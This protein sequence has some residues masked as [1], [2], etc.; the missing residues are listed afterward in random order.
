MNMSLSR[1]ERRR[2]GQSSEFYQ[3]MRKSAA[4]VGTTI[5]ACSVVAPFLTPVQADAV[6]N[7]VVRSNFAAPNT[8][9][10][11]TEI[12]TYAQPVAQAND[13]YA[14]VMIAQAI[15]ESGWGRSALSQSPNHNLFGIKGSHNGQTVY[16]NTA[17]YLNNQWLTMKEPFKKY[18]SYKESFE[19]NAR[20]LRNVSLGNGNYYYAGAWKSNT[21]SYRDA[22]QWLTGRYATAPNY[23]SSLNTVIQQYGLTKYDTPASGNAGG[24][25]TVSTPNTATNPVSKP[26]ATSSVS[27]GSQ[28]YTVASGDSVWGIANKFG[29]TMDQLCSWNNIRNN[30][31]YPG[32]K[33]TINGGTAKQTTNTGT[34]ST[35]TAS[36]GSYTVAS[37][38]SVWSVANKHGITMDQLRNWNN[39][40]NDFI[41]PG[42]RLVVKNGT[43]S[44]SQ[45]NTTTATSS[46]N[47]GRYTVASGDSVW[48]VANKHGIT[49]DQLRSWNNIKND[50]IYPGQALI[51]KNSGNKQTSSPT[52]ASTS[53]SSSAGSQKYTV[54]SGDSVWSIA[55][56]FG[57]TM[58]QFRSWNNIKNDY[59]YPGQSVRVSG[60]ATAANQTA[61]TS[62]Y[63][64]VS[65][66]SVWGIA[67]KFGISR[68]QFIQWN[69]IKDNFVYP[70]QSVRVK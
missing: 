3:T 11:I 29:I 39:I 61:S 37:G 19:D 5:T 10:F 36:A 31:I 18:P 56:K 1:K 52:T 34:I 8:A 45:A 23:A 64:V 25:A 60:T 46:T 21:S 20:T 27:S 15:L 53:I 4:V 7:T 16:M 24:G 54:A 22:T 17:E 38:D 62:N 9:A 49:M 58:D 33:L 12:A 42:Q 26:A 32:Q 67:D 55:N 41:Y 69:N 57:I 44:K 43:G 70:G 35:T 13:L 28:G 48:S 14:S 50:F 68:D 47:A 30:F 6:E 63:T 40:K 2:E 65:G 51:V 66:D 59:V